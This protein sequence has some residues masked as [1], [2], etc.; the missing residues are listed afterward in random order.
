AG[1][2]PVQD[3]RISSDQVHPRC[4]ERSPADMRH[5]DVERGNVAPTEMPGAKAEIVLLAIALGEHI[6]AEESDLIEAVPPNVEAEADADRKVRDEARVR[7]LRDLI[8]SSGLVRLGYLVAAVPIG[9]ADD[10]R[11]V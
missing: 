10:R 6:L 5:K 2:E 8:Q 4:S 7:A 3:G 1:M 11:V 9:V